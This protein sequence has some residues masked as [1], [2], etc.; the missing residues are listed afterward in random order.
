MAYYADAIK[1]T[2]EKIIMKEYIFNLETTKIEL[3]FE[4]SEYDALTPEQKSLL[5]HNFLWSNKGKCWVSRCKEGNLWRAK[6]A[7]KKLGFTE[8]VRQGERLSYGEQI[9]RQTERA[10]DRADRYE[11]YAAN[12]DKRAEQLQ[13]PLNDMHGDNAFFT[14][15]NINSSAGR[16]FRNY[17]DKLYAR[18]QK[19]FDE[20]RKSD[21]FKGKAET[22][23]DTASGEKFKDKGY[24][25]RRIKECRAEISK[26][27][28]NIISYEEK[29]FV[30]DKG[31]QL[32]KYNGEPYT[33]DELITWI[34][35]ELELIEVAIDKQGYL[36]NCLDELGGLAFSKD[37]I[38]IGYTVAVN[39]SV[40]EVIGK[41][42]QNITYKI[43]T[44]GAAGM[45]LTASYAE[46]KKII[47]ADKK[48]AEIHPF[49]VGETFT[50]TKRIY[51]I[52]NSFKSRKEEITYEIVKKSNA[53]IQLKETGADN[54]PIT[55]K[56]HKCF[57]G[58]WTFSIDGN[59]GNSFY[60]ESAETP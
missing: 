30:L 4:K 10:E 8:E 24:L 52:P 31:E 58:L 27:Q 26:R 20:Y 49:E 3:H 48:A 60:K 34:E 1:E 40:A 54:K 47:S 15:P 36:Q 29:L 6:E 43:L 33:A 42:P 44:G 50:V 57:N 41:G 16:A 35:R 19:G 45:T 7:A 39:H 37:N 23:R 21:Y 12:A 17:R 5:K 25:D 53:T 9:E 18:H 11:G 22:A 38:E 13:K 51:D 56:P 2:G 14:Q 46:I 28:K 55:R 59:L 32:K